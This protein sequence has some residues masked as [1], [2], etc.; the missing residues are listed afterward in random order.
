MRGA[1]RY[2]RSEHPALCIALTTIA[3]SALAG[4]T[5]LVT[6]FL[7]LS[8]KATARLPFSSPVLGGVALALVVGVPLAVAARLAY[9]NDQRLP[10]ATGFAGGLLI[11]WIAVEFAFIRELSFLQPLFIVLG[12]ILI[13]TGRRVHARWADARDGDLRDGD[14]QSNAWQGQVHRSRPAL[15][16]RDRQDRRVLERRDT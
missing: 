5:G 16:R 13:W 11:V 8:S 4:A 15:H 1:R 7:D 9:V 10:A 6:G 12:L 14:L 2:G 3:V